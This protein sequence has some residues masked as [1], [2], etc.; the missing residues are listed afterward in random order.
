MSA[1]A[2]DRM[3]VP[4]SASSS[5]GASRPG[6]EPERLPHLPDQLVLV[7]R[8][9]DLDDGQFEARRFLEEAVGEHPVALE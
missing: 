4:E 3:R 1:H 7:H 2:D 8:G 5:P 6:S 9:V